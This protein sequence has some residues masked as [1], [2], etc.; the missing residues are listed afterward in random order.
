MYFY[1]FCQILEDFWKIFKIGRILAE[2]PPFS[3]YLASRFWKKN[4]HGK[5]NNALRNALID[6]KIGIEVPY[7]TGNNRK[8][9]FWNI[10]NFSENIEDYVC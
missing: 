7:G 6:P 9:R 3:A 4:F 2:K 10:L 1:E 5:C 8:E